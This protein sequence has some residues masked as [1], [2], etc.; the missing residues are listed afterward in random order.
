M[1]VN[2]W[3]GTASSTVK[4]YGYDEANKEM[5]IRFLNGTHYVYHVS[6]DVFE[7]FASAPSKGRAMKEFR[8]RYHGVKVE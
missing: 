1:A 7:E 8:E 6:K 4:E 5:H 3:Y 2:R